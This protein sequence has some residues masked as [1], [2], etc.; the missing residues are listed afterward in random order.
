MSE[1]KK[2][3]QDA[4]GLSILYVEDNKALR[5]NATTL[6]KKI[7]TT[8]YSASDGK[9]GLKSFKKFNPQI[10][11]TD[12]KMPNMDGM[13]LTKHIK[14]L[15]P[16]TKVL[17]MSA[18][19][20]REYLFE[21]IKLGIFRYLKKP[22]NINELS[23]VLLE[24]IQEIKKDEDTELF[25][26]NLQSVFNHQSSIVIMMQNAEP[27]FVN[28][29]FLD[30]FNVQNLEEFTNM[31][32]DLGDLFLKHDTFLYKHDHLNW[33]EEVSLHSQKLHNIKLQ[34]RDGNFK[35][36]ILKY[37]QIPN[38]KGYGILS[39]DD[40][41][42]LNLLK[43]FDASQVKND[44]NIQNSKAMFNLLDVI[45]RNSA[46]IELHN[47]YK[48]I[49]ITHDALIVKI[50][51]QSI[52]VKTDFMQEK[53]IQLDR[54]SFI[55]SEA[56]PHVIAC[57]SIA[58]LSYKDQSVELKNIHFA[59]S[60]PVN[61]K[62]LRVVPEERHTVSLFYENSK[63][64]GDTAIEDVSLEAIKLNLEAVPA[65]LEIGSLTTINMVLNIKDKPTIIHVDAEL[66][67]K[68]ENRRDFSL[69]FRLS[70]ESDQK[71]KLGEYI[72]S[73]QM[74]IIREFKGM[75]NE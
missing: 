73:R 3:K 23:D 13:E 75:Q 31:Y 58:N 11:I 55:T 29:V 21:S 68:I 67:R 32:S 25:N 22:V 48:G 56:L 7:F 33:F 41:T 65:G 72:T 30:Y 74:S 43:L 14:D 4:K 66:F 62:A 69:V 46:K 44:K 42:E 52:V 51:D 24:T 40:I 64:H 61:R 16:N 2:L 57:D 71:K 54:R 26:T 47:F 17:V 36:F 49:R 18:F 5:E 60:S 53:A 34:D 45:Y 37:K 59:I 8:V 50:K 9:E 20:D 15:S 63:F 12:I 28:R 6:L 35:H 1:L 10:V 70:I 38:K 27:T 39:F 19:D